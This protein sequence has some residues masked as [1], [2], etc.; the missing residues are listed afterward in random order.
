MREPTP[1][2]RQREILSS[3]RKVASQR[4]RTEVASKERLEKA[5]SEASVALSSSRETAAAQQSKVHDLQTEIQAVLTDADL[6][7]MWQQRSPNIS[8]TSLDADH[9]QEL[10]RN[11]TLAVEAARNAGAG[12]NHLKRWR[13][14]RAWLKKRL[15]LGGALVLVGV[16]L[17]TSLGLVSLPHLYGMMQRLGLREPGTGAATTSPTVA[18][19]PTAIAGSSGPANSAT[20]VAGL[21]P[22]NR[23][24]THGR[25]ENSP[26][27]TPTP[28]RTPTLRPT[29]TPTTPSK[30]P[31]AAS[32][33]SKIVF[34]SNRSGSPQI[35]TVTVPDFSEIVQLTYGVAHFAPS[36]SLDG[37]KI[38]FTRGGSDE[39]SS[40]NE[41]YVMDVDG[42]NIERVTYNSSVEKQ[43]ALS[44]DGRKV[45]YRSK[46]PDNW[47]IFVADSRYG[48]RESNVSHDAAK[49]F[50]P[51]WDPTGR[52]LVFAAERVGTNRDE[53]YIMN[54][55]SGGQTRLTYNSVPDYAP[56]WSPDGKRIAFVSKRNGN[57]DIYVINVDGTGER[58]LTSDPATD[59]DPAWSP[60]GRQIAFSSDRLG[61]RDILILD[62]ESGA[63]VTQLITD[64][65]DDSHPSWS[66]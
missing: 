9:A 6:Q 15:V 11:V 19:A 41:V 33:E 21:T 23:T 52:Q 1:V 3:L 2:Q 17:G 31:K 66:R 7:D 39:D 14:R 38:T 30:L 5:L 61:D 44:A 45:A 4:A 42:G 43:P 22:Y 53:L 26:V 64:A 27:N 51:S 24:P 48:Y 54:I 46:R 28:S 18:I 58:R 56:V 55:D 62:V 40:A 12:V 35:Y 50:H 32:T 57:V 65:S 20:P 36:L 37:R 49:D 34:Q 13:W 25:P 63:V 16:L 47:E 10:A 8:E 59:T 60:D 29:R